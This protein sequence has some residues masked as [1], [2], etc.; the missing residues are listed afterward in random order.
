MQN[1]NYSGSLDISLGKWP[2]QIDLTLSHTLDGQMTLYV[3]KQEIK[4]HLT[5]I[6]CKNKYKNREAI[7]AKE[8]KWHLKG[9]IKGI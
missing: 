3:R 6:G 5:G 8:S 7:L 1:F 2:V 4:S 9:S